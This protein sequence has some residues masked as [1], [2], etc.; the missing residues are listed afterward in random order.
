MDREGAIQTCGRHIETLEKVTNIPC[1]G[2]Y[3]GLSFAQSIKEIIDYSLEIIK[4][5]ELHNFFVLPKRWIVERIFAWLENHHKLWK[6][7]ER[8]LKNSRQGCLLAGVATLLK[9]F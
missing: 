8:T 2:G 3:A 6:N 4:H 1:D 9:R 5:S 7:C